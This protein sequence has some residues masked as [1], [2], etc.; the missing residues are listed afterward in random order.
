MADKTVMRTIALEEHFATQALLEGPGRQVS[1]DPK[2]AKFVAKLTDI[3]DGRIAEMDAAGI[4]IQVLSFTAPGVEQSDGAEAVEIARD[5]NDRLADAVRSHPDRFIGLTALPTVAPETAAQ[6]LERMVRQHGF[7]GA[8]INGHTGGRYLDDKFFWP[9]LERA[10]ALQVPVYLHPTMP[11]RSVIDASYAGNYSPEVAHWLSRSA[12]GWHIETGTHVLR[13][14]L[15]GVFDRYPNLQ[16]VIGHLGEGLPFMMPRIDTRMTTQLTKL[17][18]PVSTYLRKNVYYT[19][20]GCNFIPPFLDLMLQVGVERIMFSVDYP[21]EPMEASY[22][23]LVQLPISTADRERIA[24]G[25]AEK[26]LQL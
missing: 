20:S 21:Y 19:T 26:L 3:G 5:A 22:K 7:K 1:V 13:I 2:L 17:E 10:E 16:I 25:N 9:I 15:S 18:H 8:V 14:I 11:P 6:E 24:H 23:F 12:W 4:D